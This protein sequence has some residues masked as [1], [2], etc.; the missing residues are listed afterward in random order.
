MPKSDIP[1]T[2]T[3][4][5]IDRTGNIGSG[6]KI[7]GT[8]RQEFHIDS[9]GG[10][11]KWYLAKDVLVPVVVGLIT[12]IAGAFAKYRFD[13]AR[14]PEH[15][16][17]NTKTLVAMSDEVLALA[18]QKAI[19]PEMLAKLKEIADQARAVE[20]AA[21]LIA[22]NSHGGAQRVDFWLR[23]GGGG[24]RLGDTTSFGVRSI[25]VN[26]ELYVSVNNSPINLPS[27]GVI[28]YEFQEKKCYATYVSRSP[29]ETLV[30]FNV[31]C[32]AQ[33]EK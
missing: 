32:V 20:A 7:S 15:T 6:A 18:T 22:G 17:A 14:A 16:V 12:A 13:L 26:G 8:V 23:P 31:S 21:A 28:K 11:G 30:G 1:D 25:Q 9:G 4:G 33:A 5:V 10:K 19:A 27:G 29:D 24:I 3:P 2:R